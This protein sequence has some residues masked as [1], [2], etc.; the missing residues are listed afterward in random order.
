[1]ENLL[2]MEYILCVPLRGQLHRGRYVNKSFEDYG[3]IQV[4]WFS[5]KVCGSEPR[6]IWSAVG[7]YRLNM[8]LATAGI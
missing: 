7:L 5:G 6:P 8:R 2:F 4:Q 1:M 3:Y